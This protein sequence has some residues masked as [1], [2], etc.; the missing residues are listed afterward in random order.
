[1]YNQSFRA[2][3]DECLEQSPSNQPTRSNSELLVSQELLRL[4]R[5]ILQ[6]EQQPILGSNQRHQRHTGSGRCGSPF[7]QMEDRYSGGYVNRPDPSANWLSG[8]DDGLA[9]RRSHQPMYR[10]FS[11]R[12]EF[13]PSVYRNEHL[14]TMRSF[15]DDRDLQHHHDFLPTF[16]KPKRR[17]LNSN[18][19][20]LEMLS[21]TG[22]K[23]RFIVVGV[24]VTI[25]SS[26]SR[27]LFS[28]VM[29]PSM[30]NDTSR[31]A[32]DASASTPIHRREPVESSLRAY[33][34]R[35]DATNQ[36]C[37]FI[38]AR[39]VDTLHSS[40]QT[41]FLEP[42]HTQDQG[43]DD[44]MFFNPFLPDASDY[45]PLPLPPKARAPKGIKKKKIRVH[46]TSEGNPNHKFTPTTKAITALSR[47]IKS[48]EEKK[49]KAQSGADSSLTTMD[50]VGDKSP[51]SDGQIVRF[52]S[53]I[54]ASQ[55][56]QQ[57]R[58]GLITSSV[59]RVW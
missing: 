32:N 38:G 28:L 46:P 12:A 43:R 48:T 14:S 27:L 53:S 25:Q 9:G 50:S 51:T 55:L 47:E 11:E 52:A 34:A 21:D 37:D 44:F 6:G 24:A 31:L 58:H 29:S 35:K 17:R 54:E 5:E 30:A 26:N 1:M 57:V 23:F 8:A 22:G 3:G 10:S 56:S 18:E 59:F 7:S 40:W 39:D 49:S 16:A 19:M 15:H 45:R 13:R 36:P 2:I 42:S 20:M 41:K 4:Q 33:D